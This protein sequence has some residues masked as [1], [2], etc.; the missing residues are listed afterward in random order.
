[1]A[2]SDNVFSFY[3][4]QKTDRQLDLLCSGMFV[5]KSEIH[6][7]FNRTPLLSPF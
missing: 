4:L 2:E 1:M 7:L 5:I 6:F 3:S